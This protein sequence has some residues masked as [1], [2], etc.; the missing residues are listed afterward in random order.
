MKG[1]EDACSDAEDGRAGYVAN[2]LAGG[3]DLRFL[4]PRWADP[5][6]SESGCDLQKAVPEGGHGV[7]M[8]AMY[9]VQDQQAAGM[10]RASSAGIADG[11]LFVFR[12][13]DL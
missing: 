12:H 9:A 11:A 2:Q 10:D 6:E 4:V 5:R 8:R 7:R 3:G 13:P 1:G